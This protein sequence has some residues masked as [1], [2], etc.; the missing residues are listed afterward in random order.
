MTSTASAASN[1]H[2]S[3]AQ[4]PTSDQ[5]QRLDKWLWFARMFKSRTE[6]ARMCASRHLRLDGRVIEKAH[7]A[8]RAGSVISFPK[9]GGVMVVKVCGIASARQSPALARTLYDDLA[10][11]A[12]DS[13]ALRHGLYA[14]ITDLA[15]R[16]DQPPTCHCGH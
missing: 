8:V 5:T 10:H 3:R 13:G 12:T 6:A 4:R 1:A 11:T 14:P 16:A 2:A 7:V 9:A 15:H